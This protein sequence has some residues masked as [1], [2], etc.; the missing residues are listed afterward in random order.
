MDFKTT[1]LPFAKR[2]QQPALAAHFTHLPTDQMTTRNVNCGK[3]ATVPGQSVH[4]DDD[5]LSL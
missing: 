1:P 3:L 2:Q 5:H 4:I